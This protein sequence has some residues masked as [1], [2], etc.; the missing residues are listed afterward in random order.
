MPEAL[1]AHQ[2]IRVR[3]RVQG[4]GF[5]P[6][7]WRLA[8]ELG[9]AGW[10]R[11]DGDGVEIDA[12]GDAQALARLRERLAREAPPLARVADV[13]ARDEPPAGLAGFVIAPST[14]SGQATTAVTPDAAPCAACLAELCDPA[15]RR[16]RYPFVNCTHCGPRYTI[17]Q[18]LPYDRARTSMAGFAMCADCAREYDDP[19]DRR[20]HAQ[21]IACPAC[22]PRLALTA[23]EGRALAPGDDP[24]AAALAL[25]RAGRIVA[26]KGVGGWQLLVDAR[27]PE[28]VARLRQRKHREAKPLALLLANAASFEHYAEV[29]AAVRAALESRERPIVLARKRVGCDAAFPGLAPGLA[30]VGAMLPASPLHALLFHEAAGRPAGTAWLAQPQ[31]LALVA[32]SANPGGEPIVCDDA[33]ARE[34][35]RG[36]ADAWLGHDRGIVARAD[37]SVLRVDGGLRQYIRRGRGTVPAAVRLPH[38]GPSVLAVGAHLKN[39]VCLTRGNEA[40]V[41]AHVGSLD[42][43]ATCEAFEDTIA[44]LLD[45]LEVRPERVAVDLHPD[46]HATRWA[47]AWARARDLP[48]VAVQHHHA[49]VAAVMAERGLRG[50]VLGL[51]LD[52]VGLGD[53]GAAWGGER[54]RVDERGARRSGHLR[55]LALAGGDRAAREPWRL[56]AAALQALGRGDEIAARWPAR[57]AAPAVAEL[58]A[59]GV[60][61]PPTSSAGRWFDAA[62]ALLGVAEVS[63]YEGQAAMLLEGLAEQH[64]AAEP[65]PGGHV[66]PADG[67]L[68]LL[69]LAA[70]LAESAR[71]ADVP[72][73][74]AVFHASLAAALTE[75][76]VAGAREAGVTQVVLAGGCALN[77][78]LARALGAGLQRAGLELV[79]ASELPPNDGGLSLG[80]AWVAM[81]TVIEE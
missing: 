27:Q 18:A 22:G 34:R 32:T 43:A 44:R 35:L 31:P 73:A 81:N 8:Q 16:W 29:D 21:P 46:L 14:R 20:F 12:E 23:A 60:Q 39:T 11:N 77:R 62:A 45:L 10:V 30:W 51:A 76:A 17:T 54:L 61:A 59:R 13:V 74:A 65:L 24:L 75:W 19:A 63:A 6:H 68:D 72:L 3:G 9:L 41:S 36:I 25:L 66:L 58:L 56:G 55:P 37:D 48:L 69:P 1:R 26:L 42:N 15:A 28:A 67:T 70:W 78:V 40:W 47:A 2:R 64:G 71:G 4:V 33:A 52:G 50:P 79:Q 38:A 53:D 80:Q 57:P 5:R 7:V 49:H